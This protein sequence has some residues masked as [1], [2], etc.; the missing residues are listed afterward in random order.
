MMQP[1]FKPISQLVSAESAQAL[2]QAADTSRTVNRLFM[3]FHGWYGNLFISKFATGD[4]DAEGKDRGIKSAR[5]VWAGELREFDADVVEEAAKRCKSQHVEFPPSLPQ[6]TAI[7][8]AIRPRQ[9]FAAP[10]PTNLIGMSDEL[11]SQRSKQIREEA[12]AKLRANI[13]AETGHM[14]VDAG[15]PGLKQLIAKAV[16][17]AGGDE[18]AELRR[19]DAMFA[20]REARP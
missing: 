16:A 1:M 12:M 3:L 20:K 6:F 2:P 4:L 8:R 5:A 19:L 7:C 13:D 17:L 15:L 10:K 18:V 11:R 14:R 9:V